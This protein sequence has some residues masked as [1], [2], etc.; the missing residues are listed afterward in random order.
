[1]YR[2]VSRRLI[3]FIF[4]CYMISYLDR[5]NI[6][7]AKLQMADDLQ[8]SEAAYGLGAGIF[9]IGYVLFEIP[10]NLLMTR[11][12]ARRTLVRIMILWGIASG[13]TAFVTTPMQFYIVRFLLGMF[14]AGFVP[15][16]LLYLT[17]W[18][19]GK[20]RGAA[21]ASF[22][23]AAAFAGAVGSPLSGA[24]LQGLDGVG[25]LSGWQWMFAIEAAPAIVAGLLLPRF[26]VDRPRDAKWLTDQEKA[27]LEADVADDSKHQQHQFRAALRQ[28]RLYLLGFIYFS[29]L[30][31]VYLISFYLPTIINNLGDFS[32]GTVGLIA[33]IP[34]IAATIATIW[35]GR[36]SDRMNERRWHIVASVSTGMIALLC[37]LWVQNPIISIALFTVATA[38]IF[39]AF[40]LIWPLPGLFFTGTA[41]AGALALINSMG[42]FSGFVIPYLSGWLIDIT[43]N[44]D[45]VIVMV[46]GIV[47]LGVVALL[48]GIPAQPRETKLQL[49]AEEP[50]IK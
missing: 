4:I 31:G 2:K 26:L 10:S 15:G 34:Y 46:G 20:R 24:I 35:L 8:F 39:A 22:L 48:R 28:P 41:I 50:T 18:Y 29:L 40:P 1:M 3:P 6:G 37:T 47:L 16:I 30:S 13:A 43:G 9:F 5:T 42:T 45:S 12:G 38:G 33:A 21:A 36:R 49:A 14:E 19:S 25:G 17:Y 23:A 11:I 7:F 44:L 32:A 27:L